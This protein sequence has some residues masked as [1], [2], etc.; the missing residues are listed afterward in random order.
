MPNAS[1]LRTIISDASFYE[2]QARMERGINGL[3]KVSTGPAMT[4]PSTP[5]ALR[6]PMPKREGKGMEG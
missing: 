6:E 3:P 4:N 1:V 5:Y 2:I